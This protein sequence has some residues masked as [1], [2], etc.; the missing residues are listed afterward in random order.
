MDEVSLFLTFTD[1]GTVMDFERDAAKASGIEI[2][3][4]SE[5]DSVRLSVTAIGNVFLQHMLC[6]RGNVREEFVFEA[7]TRC[8]TWDDSSGEADCQR[9]WQEMRDVILKSHEYYDEMRRTR[10]GGQRVDP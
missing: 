3:R 2:D 10:D 6:I 5:R 1:T 4:A 9:W 7:A 8:F